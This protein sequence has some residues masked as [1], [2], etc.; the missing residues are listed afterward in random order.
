ME[1]VEVLGFFGPLPTR[2]LKAKVPSEGSPLPCPVAYVELTR[3]RL[4][5]PEAQERMAQLIP[6]AEIVP[7][8]SCHQVMLENPRQLADVLLRFA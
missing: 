3:D 8:D 1:V 7:L 4:V 2:V 6:G 5:P